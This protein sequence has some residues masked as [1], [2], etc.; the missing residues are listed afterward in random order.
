LE[1]LGGSFDILAVFEYVLQS[2]FLQTTG[3]LEQKVKAIAWEMAANDHEYRYEFLQA[4]LGECSQFKD[5]N[6]IFK[7]LNSQIRKTSLSQG[8]VEIE[9]EIAL[10]KAKTLIKDILEHSSVKDVKPR[11]QQELDGFTCSQI[12]YKADAGLLGGD[13]DL[14]ETY[15]E[16]IY[17]LRNRLAHNSLANVPNLPTIIELFTNKYNDSFF[18]YFAVLFVIDDAFMEMFKK[19]RSMIYE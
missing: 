18:I 6:K 13:N 8:N 4:K 14:I 19:Y 9:Q 17:K 5:K 2:A 15:N 10:D 7:D 12:N 1:G 3:C 16:H 11:Q